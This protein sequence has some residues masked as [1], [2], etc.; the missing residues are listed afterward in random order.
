MNDTQGCEV[1]PGFVIG[2]ISEEKTGLC[3]SNRTWNEGCGFLKLHLD[4]KRV[5]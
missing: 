3:M 5:G 4:L 1:I 2:C